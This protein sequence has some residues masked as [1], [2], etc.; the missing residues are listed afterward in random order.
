MWY[1][2]NTDYP[3]WKWSAQRSRQPQLFTTFTADTFFLS[4]QSLPCVTS[5]TSEDPQ[6]NVRNRRRTRT[7]ES[8]FPHRHGLRPRQ[9]LL[10]AAQLK[11]VSVGLLLLVSHHVASG[12]K[13]VLIIWYCSWGY[14]WCPSTNDDGIITLCMLPFGMDCS[15]ESVV[16]VWQLG[17]ANYV[18]LPSA[19]HASVLL[20][21]RVFHGTAPYN[22][23][24]IA[25]QL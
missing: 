1:L 25:G 10:I 21:I 20:L 8:S 15:K 24:W 9:L 23:M 22:S 6:R 11:N 17:Q 2:F 12:L 16:S 7:Q 4:V 13:F 3:C 19:S 5:S 14:A 18:V